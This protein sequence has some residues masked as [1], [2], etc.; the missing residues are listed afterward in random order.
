MWLTLLTKLLEIKEMPSTFDLN[1][2]VLRFDCA[3]LWLNSENISSTIK[4][5]L[6][7]NAVTCEELFQQFRL[8]CA[9]VKGKIIESAPYCYWDKFMN[10]WAWNPSDKYDHNPSL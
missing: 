8:T 1:H 5:L 7:N 2:A 9:V 3:I 4:M 10:Q 6:S